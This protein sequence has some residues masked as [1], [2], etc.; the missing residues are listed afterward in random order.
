MAEHVSQLAREIEEIESVFN[1]QKK[2][3]WDKIK[4]IASLIRGRNPTH[5]ITIARGSSDHAALYLGLLIT[6]L[7][8]IP[9]ASLT[10]SF[11][12]IY[13]GQLKENSSIAIAISQSGQSPDLAALLS[14]ARDSKAFTLA[15]LNDAHSPLSQIADFTID[16]HA[17]PER[18]VAA[19]KSVIASITAGARLTAEWFNNDSLKSALDKGLEFLPREHVS[20]EK[21]EHLARLSQCYVIGRGMTLPIAQEVALKLKETC[22]IHAEAFSSAEVL[23]GPAALI[24]EGFPI[25]ALLPADEA[26]ESMLSTIKQLRVLGAKLIPFDNQDYTGINHPLL[27]P[28]VMLQDSYRHIEVAARLRG[29]DPDKPAHLS[30]VTLTV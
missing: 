22:R 28:L 11:S 17:A 1:L 27:A 29:L 2:Y 9:V 6:R 18:A 20:E 30:K 14:A 12:S 10:P 23:H 5:A 21:C 3:E 25:V 8:G 26:R 4:S 13:R 16:I 19:T 24:T 7:G 15:I